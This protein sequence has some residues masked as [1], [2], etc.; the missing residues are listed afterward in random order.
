MIIG[1]A[2]CEQALVLANMA[3]TMQGECW[4]INH[5]GHSHGVVT[6][7]ESSAYVAHLTKERA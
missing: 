6:S 2:E 4:L 7:N 1:C 5:V 3:L